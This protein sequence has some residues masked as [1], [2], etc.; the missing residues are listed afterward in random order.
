MSLSLAMIVKDEEVFLG[1]CLQ[2]V[3]GLVDEMVVVDTGS[4]DATVDLA[5]QAGARVFHFPWGND[6]AAAR[7]ESLR[8]CTGDWVL[9]L[10]AD[11]SVD[12]LDHPRIREACASAT[13]QA[14]HLTLRNYHTSGG[15]YI[16]DAMAQPNR[17]VYQEGRDYPFFVDTVGLRLCRRAPDLAYAGRI[18]E[19]LDPFF[20]VRGIPIADLTGAVIHH[21]GKMAADREQ[22]KTG[23]YLELAKKDLASDPTNTQFHFNV[24]QQGLQAQ[25]WP[26]VLA[27][28][29]AYLKLRKVAP[30]M[31]RFGAGLALGKLGRHR[32][33]LVHFETL[34][35]TEPD[36]ALALTHRGI[37]LAA[38]G[39]PRDA[40]R[41]FRKAIQT[42]PR[43]PMPY[44]SLADLLHGQG[45]MEE[46][47]AVV[48]SGVEHCP[49]H[50]L[51]LQARLLLDLR[52]NDMEQAMA[53]ARD[54]LDR[55]PT[56][57]EGLWHR[58][59]ALGAH[60]AGRS[61]EA[62]AI[63]ER[64]AVLFPANAAL[65]R[66]RDELAAEPQDPGLL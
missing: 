49:S 43:F 22:A 12:A 8:H 65:Q 42:S 26:T 19:L 6:F 45:R 37:S 13:H 7:N 17:S 31:I 18:H 23:L 20:K 29:Q 53:D 24:V 50:P 60:R 27:S 56:E 36:H 34:L 39:L 57:G 62:L 55:L 5:T 59:A 61:S 38:T 64:G 46:A 48:R 3:R 10:D 33:A 1:R 11:E 40:E 63:L 54:A 52:L 28:A 30:S 16:R 21:F 35:R 44:V 47:K 66:M 41:S 14:Y 2:S 25:D 58:L 15:Y 51:M 4:T 9:V 32:E